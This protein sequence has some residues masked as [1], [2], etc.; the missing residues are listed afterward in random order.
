V[1][2]RIVLGLGFGFVVTASCAPLV[3]RWPQAP[4]FVAIYEQQDDGCRLQILRDDRS[5]LCL[6]WV[7]CSGGAS[8]LAAVPA[9]ACVP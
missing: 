2:R 3:G 5:P 9:E 8:V 1:I 7:R 6:V 4:R